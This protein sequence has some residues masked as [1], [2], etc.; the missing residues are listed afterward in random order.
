MGLATVMMLKPAKLGSSRQSC[1]SCKVAKHKGHQL[2]QNFTKVGLFG[3]MTLL[4]VSPKPWVSWGRAD[5]CAKVLLGQHVL[6]CYG[7]RMNVAGFTASR[8]HS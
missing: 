2:A 7:W 3:S 4:P 5:N 6:M 1:V 8:E